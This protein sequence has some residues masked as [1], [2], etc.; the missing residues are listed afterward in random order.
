MSKIT[1]YLLFTFITSWGL[2]IIGSRDFNLEIS[3]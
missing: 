2:Q 3:I 1:K